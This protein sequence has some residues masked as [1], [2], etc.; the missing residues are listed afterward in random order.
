MMV[1]CRKQYGV[2]CVQKGKKKLRKN[3][4]GIRFYIVEFMRHFGIFHSDIYMLNK[5]NTVQA[6]TKTFTTMRA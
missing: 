3:I 5:Q 6:T 2:L 4:S 1:Q